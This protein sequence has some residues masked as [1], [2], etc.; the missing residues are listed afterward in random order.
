MSTET[1]KIPLLQVRPRQKCMSEVDRIS[2]SCGISSLANII[3]AD[4]SELDDPAENADRLIHYLC[5]RESYN[6]ETLLLDNDTIHI[7]QPF[8]QGIRQSGI[9]EDFSQ[10]NSTNLLSALTPSCS[11]RYSSFRTSLSSSTSSL[12]P[13]AA[14]LSGF[15]LLP[16]P[17]LAK[18]SRPSQRLTLSR[19]KKGLSTLQFSGSKGQ[20]SVGSFSVENS[21]CLEALSSQLDFL[22]GINKRM[23]NSIQNVSERAW[24]II[25]EIHQKVSEGESVVAQM[26]QRAELIGQIVA[27][28]RLAAA[29]W[30]GHSADR[31]MQKVFAE[32]EKLVRLKEAQWDPYAAEWEEGELEMLRKMFGGEIEEMIDM[33]VDSLTPELIYYESRAKFHE[34]Y[35]DLMYTLF[36]PLVQKNTRVKMKITELVSEVGKLGDIL[37]KKALPG[38]EMIFLLKAKFSS[39]K[40][41]TKSPQEWLNQDE[42]YLDFIFFLNLI[43]FNNFA[44]RALTSIERLC[45]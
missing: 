37:S 32:I 7:D 31:E 18:L 10:L 13:C 26:L 5:T 1:F 45:N 3:E 33:K 14:H 15:P 36:S 16:D 41:P 17:S 8:K 2:A 12:F 27:E 42:E 23:S 22:K 39:T 30:T 20:Q 9:F 6:E 43:Y 35:L 24:D 4:E 29:Q 38:P 44:Q 11:N 34:D 28:R 19:L 21:R 25:Q 40:D